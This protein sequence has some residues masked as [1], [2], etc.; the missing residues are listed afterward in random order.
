MTIACNLDALAPS[1]RIEHQTLRSKL[2]SGLRSHRQIGN[3]YEF[4]ID[5]SKASLIELARWIEFESRCCPFLDFSVQSA[6]NHGPLT[7]RLGGG[8]CVREFIAAE[9]RAVIR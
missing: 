7:L 6:R 3:G 4:E 8:E 9:F 1:E 5:R 2:F